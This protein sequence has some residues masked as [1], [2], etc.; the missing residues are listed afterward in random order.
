MTA[1]NI[2]RGGLFLVTER[3][4]SVGDRLTLEFA[5]TDPCEALVVDG[6][7][8]WVRDEPGE[9]SRMRIRFVDVPLEEAAIQELITGV[10]EDLTP[11][12]PST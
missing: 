3:K 9:R 6:E 2:G 8:R 7:V 4:C 11:R 5:L 1:R 10:D 12:G